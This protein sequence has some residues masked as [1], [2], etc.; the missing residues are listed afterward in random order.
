MPDCFM[1]IPQVLDIQIP[2]IAPPFFG[3]NSDKKTPDPLKISQGEREQE[4]LRYW[5]RSRRLNSAV[6]LIRE[7]ES[8]ES[9]ILLSPLSIGR[10]NRSVRSH[11]PGLLLA[12]D[13]GKYFPSYHTQRDIQTA[14][15]LPWLGH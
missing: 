15:H 14:C 13:F 10:F 3:K 9:K 6:A 7:S 8:I 11:T 1:A 4:K 12:E 5:D 2:T